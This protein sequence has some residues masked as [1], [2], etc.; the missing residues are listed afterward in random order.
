[1]AYY[2]PTFLI[3]CEL[4]NEINSVQKIN[5]AIIILLCIIV[6]LARMVLY[7]IYIYIY[8]KYRTCGG[9]PRM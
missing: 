8:T 7:I 2:N 5:D 6:P 1:M 3:S 9:C 4:I